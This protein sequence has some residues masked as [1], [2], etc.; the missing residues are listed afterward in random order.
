MFRYYI[1]QKKVFKWHEVFC[2]SRQILKKLCLDSNIETLKEIVTENYL[3]S[4][5][6]LV[7]ANKS[8]YWSNQESFIF[9]FGKRIAVKCSRKARILKKDTWG[10]ETQS[11]AVV[12]PSKFWSLCPVSEIEV[13]TAGKRFKA[14]KFILH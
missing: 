13:S 5:G 10:I 4:I 7:V 11:K 2:E 1:R 12:L 9:V 3:V 6:E 8:S 14:N